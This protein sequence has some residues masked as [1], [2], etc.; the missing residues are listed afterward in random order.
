MY[1]PEEREEKEEAKRKEKEEKELQKKRE[2]ETKEEERK[3]KEIEREEEKRK[4]EIEKE[5]QQSKKKKASAAFVN[6]FVPKDKSSSSRDSDSQHYQDVVKN[7]FLSNFTKKSDMRLAPVIRC[8]LN[9]DQK[10]TLEEH[11]TSQ[12]VDKDGMYISL[13]K[14]K[15]YEKGRY[16]P[17]WPLEEV[18]NDVIIVGK[19]FLSL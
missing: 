13:L 12:K 6:F 1:F 17:T 11:I 19:S 18:N 4:K 15:D 8:H 3:K 7:D 9:D 2:K 16:C 5:E 14:N 10:A